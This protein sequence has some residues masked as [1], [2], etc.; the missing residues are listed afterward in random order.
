[1]SIKNDGQRATR[2]SC[3]DD[4]SRRKVPN[5]RPGGKESSVDPNAPVA[6]P[7]AVPNDNINTGALEDEVDA[8]QK[9]VEPSEQLQLMMQLNI[10]LINEL[11]DTQR[12]VKVVKNQL[13]RSM[14][15]LQSAEKSLEHTWGEC[16][17]DYGKYKRIKRIQDMID[18]GVPLHGYDD[19]FIWLNEWQQP[20]DLK[21]HPNCG[22]MLYRDGF[23]LPKPNKAYI[24]IEIGELFKEFKKTE[25]SFDA[26]SELVIKPAFKTNFTCNYRATFRM[27]RHIRTSAVA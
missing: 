8:L 24:D 18:S 16:M 11:R 2:S 22:Y 26:N 12:E 25:V 23:E 13:H 10:D 1:V 19:A 6:K 17:E 3:D 14:L 20:F 15:S 4:E 9:I 21:E 5:R 27:Q 7:T